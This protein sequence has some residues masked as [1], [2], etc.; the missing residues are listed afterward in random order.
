MAKL[1]LADT[2]KFYKV[3]ETAQATNQEAWNQNSIRF[4]VQVFF[5][6][7]LPNWY[8]LFAFVIYN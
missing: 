1:N 2:T 3:G 6:N 8:N 5:K 4:V 7:A